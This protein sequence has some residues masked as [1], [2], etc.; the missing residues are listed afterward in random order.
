MIQK[1]SHALKNRKGF[2]LVELMVVVVIIGILAAIA[3]PTYNSAQETAKQGAGDANARILNGG[4]TQYK[5]TNPDVAVT[6]ANLLTYLD[7]TA[8][9]IKYVKLKDGADKTDLTE[10]DYVVDTSVTALAE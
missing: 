9:N 1:I 7:L 5:A 2:T 4:I 6:Q 8:A 10:G 3:V